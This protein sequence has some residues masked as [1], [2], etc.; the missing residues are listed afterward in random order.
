[1]TAFSLLNTGISDGK[2][3]NIS[4]ILMTLL[5]DEALSRVRLAEKT[6]LSN[7]TIT[8]L[9]GE[10][11]AL[12]VIT[13]HGEIKRGVGRPQKVLRLNREAG[14]VVAIHFDVESINIAIADLYADP[15]AQTQIPNMRD[16]PWEVALA[17][18]VR[19]VNDLLHDHGVQRRRL[20]GVGVA[21][22]GLVDITTGVNLL[23]PNLRWRDVPLRAYFTEHLGLPVI[24]DN[25]VRTMALYEALFGAARGLP[26]AAF[27]YTR[28][29][30]GSGLLMNGQMVHGAGF[31]A[32]EI[33][34]TTVMIEGGAHCRCG[35]Q[36]CLETV[37]SEPVLL[38]EA[39]QIAHEHPSGLLAQS[40]VD[41]TPLTIDAV[42][43]AAAAGDAELAAML[44]RRVNLFA[45]ALAN[46]MNIFN[47]ACIILGGIFTKERGTLL[48]T[49]RRV[50]HERAFSS[51]NHDVDIIV[52]EKG[53]RIGMVGAASLALDSLLYRPLLYRYQREG[54]GV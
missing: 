25:N 42:F 12:G 10:L 41:D 43:A 23:A 16:V 19:T 18:C 24:V 13:E 4:T 21:A 6:G 1:M 39:M 32:G 52:T 7:A 35:N 37:F 28:I 5:E 47:P 51:L 50:A 48:P 53:D 30:I 36:G 22:S 11:A 15:I 33:G 49:L 34:H 31:A 20:L 9:V 8:N 3:Q 17:A 46:L 54:V 29:G 26:S 27:V 40:L 38:A 44:E 2:Q 14:A 45:V